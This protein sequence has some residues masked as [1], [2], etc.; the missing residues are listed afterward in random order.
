MTVTI[1]AVDPAHP[2]FSVMWGEAWQELMAD[3]SYIGS[4]PSC[5]HPICLLVR[6][7]AAPVGIRVYG[8]RGEI[9]TGQ[10]TY[11]RK[12]HRQQSVCDDSWLLTKDYLRSLGYGTLEYTIAKT[13]IAMKAACDKRGDQKIADLYLDG[14]DTLTGYRYQ[15]S[16]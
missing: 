14:T 11:V 9:A 2:D 4:A 6:Q 5:T 12:P 3:N 7:D 10:M 8:S 15:T 1:E 13:A 16:L